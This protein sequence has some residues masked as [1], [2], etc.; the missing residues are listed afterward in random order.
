MTVLF[1]YISW[2]VIVFIWAVLYHFTFSLQ[3]WKGSGNTMSKIT[4]LW[5]NVSFSL[6]QK[7]KVKKE[8]ELNSITGNA[9]K[10]TLSEKL[11]E[12]QA[13]QKQKKQ[14]KHTQ[15][16]N[17]SHMYFTF[18]SQSPTVMNEWKCIM[19]LIWLTIRTTF[20][21]TTHNLTTITLPALVCPAEHLI[22]FCTT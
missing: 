22:T 18:S 10:N 4:S 16:T 5:K 6:G 2:D 14:R 11:P 20:T 7:E 9:F 17:R 13:K 3:I 15:K 12:E 8:N 19:I 1:L 21:Q